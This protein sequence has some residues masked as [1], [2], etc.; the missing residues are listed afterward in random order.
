[1]DKPMGITG[2]LNPSCF[3][4]VDFSGMDDS[5]AARLIIERIF[6]F[7]TVNEINR[8]VEYYGKVTVIEVLTNLNYI[9]PKTFNYIKKV[10]QLPAK[11]FR[12]YTRKRLKNQP[13][14]S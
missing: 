9:D 8:V 2:Q 3:W 5:T 14:N 7:G 4:D 11:K 1:M 10:F 13:W 6:N 12:C